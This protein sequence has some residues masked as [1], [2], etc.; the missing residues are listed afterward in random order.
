AW[1]AKSGTGGTRVRERAQPTTGAK[2]VSKRRGRSDEIARDKLPP[3]PPPGLVPF[4]QSAPTRPQTQ[5]A[6]RRAAGAGTAPRPAQHALP[7]DVRAARAYDGPQALDPELAQSVGLD[8][9]TRRGVLDRRSGRDPAHADVLEQVP[10]DQAHRTG[11]QPP[12]AGLR[13]GPVADLGL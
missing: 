8:H 7:G 12:A 6:E 2:H 10:H 11:H 1:A 4:C 5:P 13:V 3:A 9:V